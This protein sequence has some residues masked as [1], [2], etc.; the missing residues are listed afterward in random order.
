MNTKNNQPIGILG[1]TFNPIHNGHLRVALELYERLNLKE[2]RLIPS[3]NPP[4]R[5][6]SVSA[7][8][9]L[10]MVQAAV[11]N[12]AGLC[13]DD[14]ELYRKKPSY[15]IETLENLRL[16]YPSESLC[17]IVG[18]DAFLK[19]HT[20]HR[21]KELLDFTHLLLIQRE[22]Y[23]FPKNHTMTDFLITHQVTDFKALRL[24]KAGMIFI[25]DIPKLDISATYIRHLLSQG[26]NPY[27][28]IP[29]SVL[30]IIDNY[31]LYR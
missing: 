12:V 14:R 2:V 4:H 7:E 25:Q 10:K 22:G 13:V 6:P 21:W 19:L 18:T 23:D 15:T 31:Y 9:R 30:G 29:Q 17:L 28:L 27:Y 26:R 11:K 16:D 5:E 24:K 20:W 3:A 1:G 8:F